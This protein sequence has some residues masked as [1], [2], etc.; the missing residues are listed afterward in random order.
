MKSE[1]TCIKI[2]KL[3]GEPPD[4]EFSWTTLSG[5][6]CTRNAMNTESDCPATKMLALSW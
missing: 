6:V 4:V 1:N 2:F 5:K 3:S